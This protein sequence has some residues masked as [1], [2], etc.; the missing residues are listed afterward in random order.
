MAY[1]PYPIRV[2]N[3]SLFLL[4][5]ID[6]YD[7]LKWTR[8]WREPGAFEVTMNRYMP[9]AE[10]LVKGNF[11]SM[12]RG[13]KDR[14]GQIL[15][16][17]NVMEGGKDTEKVTVS[18]LDLK[19]IL[20]KR[21]ALYGTDTSTGYDSQTKILA[22]T[23]MRHYLDVNCISSSITKRNYSQ[24]QLDTSWYDLLTNAVVLL[25]FEGDYYDHIRATSWTKNG[26]P[27]LCADH[28]GVPNHA[29]LTPSSGTDYFS[30]PYTADLAMGAGDFA[31]SYWEKMD[32]AATHASGSLFLNAG[33][34]TIIVG[35]KAHATDNAAYASS[36]GTTWDLVNGVLMGSRIDMGWHMWTFTRNGNVW[37][38]YRDTTET[39]TTTMAGTVYTAGSGTTLLNEY[40]AAGSNARMSNLM[41][42]KGK[43]LS[44]AEVSALYNWTLKDDLKVTTY[45]ARFQKLA[46]VCSQIC[47]ETGVGYDIEFNR[48]TGKFTFKTLV[49]SYLPATVIFSTDYGNAK[50]YNFEEN[51]MECYN[52]IYACGQG[53]A[54]ARTVVLVEDGTPSGLDRYEDIIDARD[55]NTADKLT[56]RGL[57]RLNEAKEVNSISF[58]FLNNGSFQYMSKTGAGDFDL[59]DTVKAIYPGVA[60][61]I[62]RII[63]VTETYSPSKEGNERIELTVGKEPIDLISILARQE[64]NNSVG[65]RL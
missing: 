63:E 61:V 4:C 47:L 28:R 17:R 56:E 30:L 34:L 18:G 21:G 38:T 25:D 51:I 55:L 65:R 45:D 14:L 3:S 11:V 31:I 32:D 43:G 27:T 8:R 39:S 53:V 59:G 42:L 12:Y 62:S 9:G 23:A 1:N 40:N 54:N 29:Y 2:Y 5:E 13:G 35:W 41:I 44:A 52:A 64:R 19:G 26:S 16:R 37:K 36:N 49:G 48:S 60:T 57:M 22:G 58:E 10:N 15:L 20:M 6:V 33:G 50:G 7:S 46:D 24:L